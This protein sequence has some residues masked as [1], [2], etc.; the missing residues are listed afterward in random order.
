MYCVISI[1]LW[2]KNS[3]FVYLPNRNVHTWTQKDGS[4]RCTATSVQTDVIT[5][6]AH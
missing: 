5:A 1:F 2:H 3:T 6:M 4:K